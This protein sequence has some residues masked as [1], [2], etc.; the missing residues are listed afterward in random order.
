IRDGGVIKE[1]Y[2]EKL[3]ELRF[4]TSEGK[5]WISELEHTERRR[6]AIKNLKVGYNQVFGYYIEVTKTHMSKVPSDYIRKQTLTNCERFI[7]SELKEKEA[8]ILGAEE[9][10]HSLEQELYRNV[11]K[12][13]AR[14]VTAIQNVASAVARLDCYRSF[15]SVAISNDYV[16]PEV[17]DGDSIRIKDGRHP[18]VERAMSGFV[19]N[20]SHMDNKDIQLVILTGPNMA[21]K[22][23]Y[24]RQTALIVLMAQVG[25]FVPARYASI[26]VVDR[27]FTRVGAFDDL[28][29]GQSTFMVEMLE[30]ANILNSATPRSLVLLDEIGRG[31]ST[32]DGLSIAW[33]VAEY[34]H[35]IDKK[36]V[37]TMFA[38]HYHQ[39]T[40]LASSLKRTK[41]SH[42]AVKEEKDEITFLR[43]VVPGSTDKSYGIQVAKLAGIPKAVIDRSKGILSEIEAQN[44]AIGEAN[45]RRTGR[46]RPARPRYTQVLL[47]GA[48]EGGARENEVLRELKDLDLNAMTPLA[49]LQKLSELKKRTEETKDG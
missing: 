5:K 34:I 10:I 44:I 14:D 43:K 25:C 39:L 18:V 17:N 20:D 15:A 30:L 40:E 3:D 28:T 35:N 16:M 2:D 4:S 32:F 29:S 19:P 46:G 45:E 24:M 48:Q 49:A 1:G 41:N 37:K 47:V 27:I 21:G 12:K 36:G 38:T 13:I 9:K 11:L 42:I 6:T 23:T 7:T 33:A 8:V 31:T 22:S 26:G